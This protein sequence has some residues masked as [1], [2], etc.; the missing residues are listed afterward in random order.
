MTNV[1]NME[2]GGGKCAHLGGEARG[3]GHLEV[4]LEAEQRRDEDEDLG[5]LREH[6][7]VLQPTP[8]TMES[9]EYMY[10]INTSTKHH[11]E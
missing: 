10:I 7:P 9:I 8:T 11:G 6:L 3:E 4:A 5:D 2:G 1:R